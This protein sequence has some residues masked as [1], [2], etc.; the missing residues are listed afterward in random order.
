[1]ATFDNSQEVL[2]SR[3]DCVEQRNEAT[4]AILQA[5]LARNDAGVAVLPE[6]GVSIQ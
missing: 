1:V 2:E 4:L 5:L 3:L 6:M